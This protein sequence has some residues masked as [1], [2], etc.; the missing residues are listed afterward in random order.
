[1]GPW[2]LIAGYL[3]IDVTADA[4]RLMGRQEVAKTLEGVCWELRL[5][6]TN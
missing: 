5:K 3:H 2:V 1:M 6:R 4:L